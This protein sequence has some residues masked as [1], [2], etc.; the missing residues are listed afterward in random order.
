MVMKKNKNGILARQTLGAT[1]L[2]LG[3]HTQFDFGSNMGWVPTKLHLFLS[4]CKTKNA[5]NAPLEIILE[6]REL[7]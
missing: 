2:K 5:K 3:M 7:D 1:N 4:L 6:P